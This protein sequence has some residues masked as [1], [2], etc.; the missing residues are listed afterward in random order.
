MGTCSAPHIYIYI[1]IVHRTFVRLQDFIQAPDPR[2]DGGLG[3]R[4]PIEGGP[5]RGA[6]DIGE[7]AHVG[8]IVRRVPGRVTVLCNRKNVCGGQEAPLGT[9]ATEGEEVG[10]GWVGVK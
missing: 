1:Y 7:R 6:N 4:A 2:Q 10:V 8:N 5:S 3:Q 9:G